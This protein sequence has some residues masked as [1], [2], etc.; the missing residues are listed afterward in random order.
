[1]SWYYIIIAERILISHIRRAGIFW[2]QENIQC[3]AE[4]HA[5]KE[6][7]WFSSGP[8]TAQ[9]HTSILRSTSSGQP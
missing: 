6:Q 1:M 7:N 2:Q 5:G 9:R 3:L 4:V 8:H